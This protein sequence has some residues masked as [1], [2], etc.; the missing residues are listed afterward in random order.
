M[1][2]TVSAHLLGR[3]L[4]FNRVVEIY[5]SCFMIRRF[6]VVLLLKY[7]S[8]IIF[9]FIPYNIVRENHVNILC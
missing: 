2:V 4:E 5:S 3:S 1:H 9:S 6:V 7:I 8:Y